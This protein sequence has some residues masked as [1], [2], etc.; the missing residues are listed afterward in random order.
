MT[1]GNRPLIHLDRWGPIPETHPAQVRCGQSGFYF[2]NDG[3][4]AYEVQLERFE[5]GEGVFAQS[6][7]VNRVAGE[8]FALVW[9]EINFP[10]FSPKKW[11]LLSAMQQAA[12]LRVEALLAADY[13]VPVLTK[14]RDAD[15][16]WYQSRTT[17]IYLPGQR[18]VCF[19]ATEASLDPGSP[20][21]VDQEGPSQA[22]TGFAGDPIQ[23]NPAPSGRA[24]EIWQQFTLEAQRKL[25]AYDKEFAAAR[26]R[27]PSEYD[28]LL[29]NRELYRFQVW[30]ERTLCLVQEYEDGIKYGRWLRFYAEQLVVSARTRDYPF[31]DK[32]S[33]IAEL[34]LQLLRAC[35][36]WEAH[37]LASINP[38]G[39][40]LPFEANPSPVPNGDR[41]S[42]QHPAGEGTKELVPDTRSAEYRQGTDL[43]IVQSE[44][45]FNGFASEAVR[46][47]ALTD[48]IEC[49]NCSEAALARTASVD[50]ADLSKWKKGLL[51]AGS[52]KKARI[53]KALRKNE[54]P[55]PIVNRPK[56]V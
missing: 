46:T 32:D 48:Y 52:E 2:I 3:S 51:P 50:P 22:F 31:S 5:I 40:A 28:L 20:P 56:D 27:G 37:S 47:R 30:A 44:I 16:V 7:S 41:H 25:L 11:D 35:R 10:M 34:R 38:P 43:S 18:R 33:Y 53:E 6:E 26:P 9:L 8:G 15:G 12:D 42:D 39:T 55:T 21:P 49:W 1:Q 45:G 29:I 13:R 4:P 54:P 14:Y 17:F 36:H 19:S 23:P 24:A